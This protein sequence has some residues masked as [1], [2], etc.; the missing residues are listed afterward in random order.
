[1]LSK[2]SQ[3]TQ[4]LT[5]PLTELRQ[6]IEAVHDQLLEP[7]LSAHDV[8]SDLQ[9]DLRTPIGNI[10]ACVTLIHL[11]GGL[12]ESQIELVDIMEEAA[13]TLIRKLDHLLTVNV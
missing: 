12:T 9:H 7:K 4:L 8:L 11:D 3:D 10:L 13:N 5:G 2:Q 1:M 6:Q